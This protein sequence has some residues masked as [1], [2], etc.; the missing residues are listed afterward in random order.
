M[1]QNPVRWLD[2][3]LGILEKI[4]VTQADSIEK[5]SQIC[6]RAIS[7][8]GVVH[9]FGCGHSRIP[10]EEM[11]PRY[12]SYPGFHPIVELSTSFHSQV[13]GAN[14]QRQAMFIEEVSGLAE[15]IIK[16]FRIKPND[17]A[18]VFSASGVTLVTVEFAQQCKEIGVPV[19]GV[20]SLAQAEAMQNIE[21]V[22]RI[23]EY[24]DVVIDL[25]TPCGDAACY[26]SGYDTPVGPTTTAAAVAIVNC[27]K[28]R[29]AELLAQAS[30]LPPVI[31]SAA[32]VGKQRSAALFDAAYA[33]Y[34]RRYGD[35]IRKE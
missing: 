12:G 18:M 8:D 29:T 32:L 21:S 24:A 3:M 11:F 15:A 35:R 23:S 4:K 33:E 28:V 5:A 19:I 16:N 34:G 30:K 17:A 22:R 13:V 20:L 26:V 7:S 2:E 31:T 25:C 10:V 6:F 27:I 9:L 1:I 14:G